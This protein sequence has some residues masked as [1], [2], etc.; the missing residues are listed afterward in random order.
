LI[1]TG[2]DRITAATNQPPMR[3][4]NRRRNCGL[5]QDGHSPTNMNF[6]G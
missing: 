6:K 5:N 3:R 2:T 4:D 1:K